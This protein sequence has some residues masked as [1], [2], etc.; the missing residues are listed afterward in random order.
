[1]TV[2]ITQE[3]NEARL[4]APG[5]P[6]CRQQP[7][8]SAHLRR[9]ATCH[10]GDDAH[11]RDAGRD[12]LTKPAGTIGRTLTPDASEGWVDHGDRHRHAGAAGQRQRSHGT[13]S[14]DCSGTDGAAT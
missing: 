9:Y 2:A 7:G 14:R 3:H 12:W 6:G 4:A 11:E 13:G 10:P 1:M 8:A 5:I